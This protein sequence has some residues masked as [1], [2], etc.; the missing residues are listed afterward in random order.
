M[1]KTQSCHTAEYEEKK[2]RICNHTHTHPKFILNQGDSK[3]SCKIY[4]LCAIV[5][6]TVYLFKVVE[7][8]LTEHCP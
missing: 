4:F 8:S 6:G 1:L 3:T 7:S 2:K 5:A